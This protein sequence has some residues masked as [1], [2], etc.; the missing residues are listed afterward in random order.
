MEDAAL[1]ESKD[2]G[3]SLKGIVRSPKTRIP[4]R[5]GNRAQAACVCT[6]F[7]SIRKIHNE[8][9]WRSRPQARSAPMTEEKVGNRSITDCIQN[10]FPIRL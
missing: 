3:K 7:S 10:I 9:T 1:F 8:Y 4:A 6:Q 2:A 5:N